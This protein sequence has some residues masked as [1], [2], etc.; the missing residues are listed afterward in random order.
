MTVLASKNQLRGS[1]L[2][3]ALVEPMSEIDDR[4]LVSERAIEFLARFGLPPPPAGEDAE[5]FAKAWQDLLVQVLRQ[6]VDGPHLIYSCRALARIRGEP[7]TLRPEVWI[8]RWREEQ[9]EPAP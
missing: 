1:L 4:P 7:V 5:S 6:S 3:W 9:T 8:A 2:R